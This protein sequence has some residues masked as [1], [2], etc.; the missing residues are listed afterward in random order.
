[1]GNMHHWL[2][3]DGRPWIAILTAAVRCS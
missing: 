2:I 1:M 3:G